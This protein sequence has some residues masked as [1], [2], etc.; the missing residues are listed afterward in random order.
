MSLGRGP[1]SLSSSL[2]LQGGG[3]HGSGPSWAVHCGS[4]LQLLKAHMA[5]ELYVHHQLSPL[6]R[7][8]SKEKGALGDERPFWPFL[9]LFYPL[10][11]T[12]IYI[13]IIY[14]IYIYIYINQIMLNGHDWYDGS[15]IVPLLDQ[16]PS[17]LPSTWS[18]T[19]AQ[20]IA[21]CL[22]IGTAWYS[23]LCHVPWAFNSHGSRTPFP[24]TRFSLFSSKFAPS[25]HCSGKQP[26]AE[27]QYGTCSNDVRLPRCAFSP[28]NAGTDEW[29]AGVSWLRS[30]WR[31]TPCLGVMGCND[32]GLVFFCGLASNSIFMLHHVAPTDTLQTHQSAWCLCQLARR[33]LLQDSVTE[34]AGLSVFFQCWLVF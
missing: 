8:A 11:V 3:S 24:A 2:A 14:F 25:C 7:T 12:F 17:L 27:L 23:Y 6:W 4:L 22:K 28:S 9:I 15:G 16:V 20:S 21:D 13:Y 19:D 5:E 18:C 33:A 31:C 26:W 10:W 30:I 32:S 1:S 29:C 34:E